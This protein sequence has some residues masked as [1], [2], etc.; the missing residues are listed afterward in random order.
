[1]TARTVRLDEC[2][3]AEVLERGHHDRGR[4][5]RLAPRRAGVGRLVEEPGEPGQE[6][7]PAGGDRHAAT[8]RGRWHVAAAAATTQPPAPAPTA[9]SR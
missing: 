1:M 2:P 8:R 6:Q 3:A 9:A 5:E 7:Q 4:P